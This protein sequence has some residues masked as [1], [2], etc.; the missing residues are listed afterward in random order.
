MAT[1]Q[2]RD[3]EA[4]SLHYFDTALDNLL[5][6]QADQ[7]DR[8]LAQV[9]R[10]QIAARELASGEVGFCFECGVKLRG[11]SSQ[12]GSC[13]EGIAPTRPQFDHS[14]HRRGPS[15]IKRQRFIDYD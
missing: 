14:A 13:K 1:E 12:C 7:I 5:E 8:E 4:L 3:A 2:G 9:E 10:E 11:T 15:S 6:W